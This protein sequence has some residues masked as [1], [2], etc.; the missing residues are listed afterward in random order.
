MQPSQV[1]LS[2]LLELIPLLV[3]GVEHELVGGAR[4]VLG[5]VGHLLRPLLQLVDL[6][7]ALE[8]GCVR[9]AHLAGGADAL[10][11]Q[12][13]H[14]HVLAGDVLGDVAADLAGGLAEELLAVAGLGP[15]AAEEALEDKRDSCESLLV[16]DSVIRL[17]Y[18]GDR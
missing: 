6:L 3:L 4:V 12:L 1:Q 16:R 2:G 13:L 15:A 7:A 17:S 8:E 9:L 10:G 18:R 14:G 5:L 11:L